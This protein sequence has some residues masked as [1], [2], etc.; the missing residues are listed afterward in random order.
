MTIAPAALAAELAVTHRFFR[1]T[2][3]CFATADGGFTP[4]ADAYTV[5]QHIAHVARTVDWF[6][7]A[8]SRDAGFDL[9][10]DT[11]IAEARA[12][13]DL[14][15]ALAWLDR[16]FAAADSALWT[17]GPERL[18][19]PL[20]AGPIMAGAPRAAVV[21]GIVDHSAH[22]R[23]ALAVYARLCGR[24]PAMPYG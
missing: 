15:A 13:Q 16:S 12:V 10:F 17:L 3:A 14:E 22:H 2:V 8:A 4:V 18:A 1:N 21:G 20:P 19:E 7:E 23:G 11:H 24:L 5:A 6:V 9:D